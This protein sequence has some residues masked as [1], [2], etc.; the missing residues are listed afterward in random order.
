MTTQVA[1][2]AGVACTCSVY[3]WVGKEK[4]R[5]VAVINTSPLRFWLPILFLPTDPE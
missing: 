1:N 3:V 4:A 2:E 5:T